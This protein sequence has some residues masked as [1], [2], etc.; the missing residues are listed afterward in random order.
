MKDSVAAADTQYLAAHLGSFRL[1]RLGSP[2][3]VRPTCA[4]PSRSAHRVMCTDIVGQRLAAAMAC[5]YLP[6]R[7]HAAGAGDDGHER[8]VIIGLQVGLDN[9]VA[10]AR[11][12]QAVCVAVTAVQRSPNL[13]RVCIRCT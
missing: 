5:A 10:Q 7:N 9:Q 11:R 6:V 3:A 13:R 12:Q 1:V 4:R 2:Q 8:H